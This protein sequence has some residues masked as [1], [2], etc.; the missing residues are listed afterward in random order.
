[1]VSKTWDEIAL[2]KGIYRDAYLFGKGADSPFEI[3]T[4]FSSDRIANYNTN[5]PS[6]GHEITDDY[7]NRAIKSTDQAEALEL[8]KK[9]QWDGEHGV[10]SLGD[11]PFIPM[12]AF[13]HTFFIRDG[14]EIGEFRP[15]PH[16]GAYWVTVENIK[17]WEKK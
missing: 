17:D 4:N 1:M 11:S 8:W 16:R 9:A 7:L 13:H 15:A 6:Y 3:Y 10:N 2:E 5:S 14:V 12:V